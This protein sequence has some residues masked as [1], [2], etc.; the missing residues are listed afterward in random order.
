[1]GYF[2]WSC[3]HCSQSLRAPGVGEPHLNEGVAIL[4]NGSIIKGNYNGYGVLGPAD[5]RDHQPQVYHAKCWEGAGKPT[6]WEHESDGADDQGFFVDDERE[7]VECGAILDDGADDDLCDG[8]YWDSQE[9]DLD[10]CM[11]CGEELDPDSDDGVRC[12]SCLEDME[13]DEDEE[14]EDW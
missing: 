7:C 3:E 1:M 13:R 9:E 11:D 8:C 2:S 10:Y 12:E 14:E 5:L 4:E 6:D